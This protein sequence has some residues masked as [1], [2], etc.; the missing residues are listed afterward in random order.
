MLEYK[1]SFPSE[2]EQKKIASYFEKLDHLITLHQ[3][4]TDFYKKTSFYFISS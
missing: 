4:Q 1:M 3:R 2:E